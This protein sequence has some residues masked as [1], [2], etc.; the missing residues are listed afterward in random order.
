[1]ESNVTDNLLVPD[2]SQ[3]IT[4]RQLLHIEGDFAKNNFEFA[5]CV[6]KELT[7]EVLHLF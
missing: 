1:M 7:F 6:V 2:A 3:R 4:Q 5:M